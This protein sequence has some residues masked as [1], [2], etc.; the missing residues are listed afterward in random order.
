MRQYKRLTEDSFLEIDKSKNIY[1]KKLLNES[2]EN[3][4][5]ALMRL[6]KKAL[7]FDKIKIGLSESF[8][9]SNI[10]KVLNSLIKEKLIDDYVI[11]GATALLY[12]STPH[13]TEDID[14]F[15]TINHSSLII[16]LS[17]IYE[18]LIQNFNAKIEN[19]YIL[20]FNNPIQFLMTGDNITKEAIKN[21]NKVIIKGNTFKLFSLEYLIAIMLFLNK[22]KYKERL[23]I[24]KEENKYD[25][26]VLMSILKKHNLIQ[27]WENIK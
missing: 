8:D 7:F 19:E 6:Q 14:V 3:K 26:N 2:Y 27:K 15:I 4:L 16:D 9:L 12:Y 5:K 11:G 23:R 17:E 25:N 10:I 13:L 22:T 21:Y 20:L 1:Q 18:Y 24:V